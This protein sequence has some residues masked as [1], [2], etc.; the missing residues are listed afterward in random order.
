MKNFPIKT[1]SLFVAF[2]LCACFGGAANTALVVKQDGLKVYLD[3]SD[4]PTKPK[5]GAAF[6]INLK[7]A[8]IINP[9]TGKNLGK[10][11]TRQIYGKITWVDYDYSLGLLEEQ[12][13]V[14]GLEADIAIPAQEPSRG[15]DAYPVQA[16]GPE[17]DAKPTPIWQSGNIT[18]ETKAAAAGNITGAGQELILAFQDNTINIFTLEDNSLK[19]VLTYKLSPLRRIISLDAAD[20]KGTGKAQL[21]AVIFDTSSE[22]FSTFV[23]EY[24]NNKLEQT[25]TINGIVKGIAPFNGP[26]VLYMQDVSPSA[27]KFKTTN[28][29]KL[30]YKNNTFA[31]GEKISAPRFESVFGFNKAD[32]I[33]I[34]KENII[35][36][37]ANR[38]LR[39][40][41]DKKGNYTESPAD[42]DFATTPIRVKYKNDVLRFPL[43]I[44]LFRDSSN[45]NII[46]VGVENK[47]KLG[48]L[49][50]KFGSY[51]SARLH[52]LKWTGDTIVKQA[53]ADLGGVVYDIV[54]APLGNF[55]NVIIVP[56]TAGTG[57]T[58]VQLYSAQ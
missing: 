29:A 54:Q 25:A 44:A 18:G 50:D 24:Q 9:Q 36:S 27:G 21:F 30:I 41:Y 28:P 49:A 22:R 19:E 33:G 2:V 1:L 52:F 14:L 13:E 34:G 20:I 6:V 43:S 26:R 12:A 10:E 8:D 48:M 4:F 5:D 58:R 42:I 45:N 38:R 47:A 31:K 37:A 39:V 55:N 16:P 3:T 56:F 53:A 23:F 15:H 40:Q 46:I 57:F 32:F 17:W 35:Y 51:Q 11:I 7:G